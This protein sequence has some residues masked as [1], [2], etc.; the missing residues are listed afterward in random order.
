[1]GLAGLMGFGVLAAGCEGPCTEA[2]C[3]SGA[4]IAITAPGGGAV[5]TFSGSARFGGQTVA[6]DCPLTGSTTHRC[7]GSGIFLRTDAPPAEVELDVDAPDVG[8]FAGVVT[9]SE[10]RTTRPNGPG[11]EPVC[12]GNDAEVRLQ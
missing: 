6:F 3:E 9:L 11:C 7:E 12:R 4:R 1:M 10:V 2:G 5:D 8:T